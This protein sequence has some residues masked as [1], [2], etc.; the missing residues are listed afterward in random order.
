MSEIVERAARAIAAVLTDEG[1]PVYPPEDGDH[2]DVERAR[3]NTVIVAARS[4]IE[5]MREPTPEMIEAGRLAIDNAFMAIV[6]TGA[7]RA[8]IPEAFNAMID[9]SLK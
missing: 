4:A 8:L 5:A 7:I 2:D 1:M 9:E 3:W 6:K